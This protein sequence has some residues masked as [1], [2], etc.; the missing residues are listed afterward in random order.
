MSRKL[1]I[2]GNWKMNKT[3][4]EAV[5][6]VKGLAAEV[7]GIDNVDISLFPT[8][9]SVLAALEAAKGTNVTI[10][11]QNVHFA[12]SGAYTGELSTDMLKEFGITQVIIG[13]S[14]RRQYFNETDE[15]VNKRTLAALAAGIKPLTCIGETLEERESG[16]MEKV[17]DRQIRGAFTGFSNAQMEATVVAYEP[18]WAIGTGV[19]ASP[20]QAQDAHAFI[21]KTLTELFGT[22]TAQKI[23]IQY[24][25]SVKAGNVAELVGKEDIDGA[26]VGG[27]SLTVE[28]FAS[29][30]KN[31]SAAV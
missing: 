19:T 13:H 3:A 5:E 20:E 12:A 9:L 10:G 14:E 15:T 31:A 29:L 25:G 27:A 6:T 18:V 28:D 4:V 7:A 8:N 16:N 2:A 23:I 22:D 30:L 1:F 11:V 21:R 17:L 24:G 26:L